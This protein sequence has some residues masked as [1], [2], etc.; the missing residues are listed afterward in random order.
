MGGTLG[1]DATQAL[2]DLKF[3]NFPIITP[4]AT[5]KASPRPVQHSCLSELCLAGGWE[6]G[7]ED[8]WIAVGL[9]E[10]PRTVRFSPTMTELRGES[11]QH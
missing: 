1:K 10:T 11:L 2:Q 8:R 4:S 5:C 9:D 6:G 7:G 3:K